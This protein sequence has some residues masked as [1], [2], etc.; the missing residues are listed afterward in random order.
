MQGLPVQRK[1]LGMT[2]SEKAL[3]S[4]AKRLCMEAMG[5][6]EERNHSRIA[7]AWGMR[8]DRYRNEARAAILAFLE[9]EKADGRAMMPREITGA[10]HVAA[11][12]EKSRQRIAGERNSQKLWQAM[13]DAALPDANTGGG[14]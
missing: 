14:R 5:G 4:A 13:F 3:E 11:M 1:V 9:A 8:A 7:L 2:I 6:D 10:M 12:D